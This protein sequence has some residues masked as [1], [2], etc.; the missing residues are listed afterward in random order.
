VTDGG[1]TTYEITS[2]ATKDG[3]ST[4]I[5]SYVAI[6]PPT[7]GVS[8]FD[9]ALCSL[10]G[11]IVLE[12]QTETDGDEVQGGDVYA[13]GN[14]ILSG[15]AEVNGDAIATGTIEKGTKA[16]IAGAEIEG[17]TNPPAPPDINYE[18]YQMEALA[19]DC[20]S[21]PDAVSSW[22]NPAGNYVDPVRVIVDMNISGTGTWVFYDKVC[23]G[24]NLNIS[25][26][27]SVVFMQ[28]VKVQGDINISTSGN[29]TFEDTV[30]VGD[31]LGISSRTTLYLG[32][33]VYVVDQ[34]NIS[35]QADLIGA[36]TIVAGGTIVLSGQSQLPTESIP[37]IIS[38][39]P[40]TAV[41]ISGQ[42]WTCAMIYAPNGNIALSGKSMLYG[43]AVGK[44]IAG[45]GQSTIVYPAGMD[46]RDDLPRGTGTGGRMTVLVYTVQ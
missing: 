21:I 29:I 14:V 40:D 6:I 43:A 24:R 13:V 25:S 44:D 27:A 15:K 17:D 39:A 26:S 33:T 3:G 12:G 38:L 30:Y 10:D 20:E 45:S 36:E 5:V 34:I 1:D 23:I 42:S 41:T 31:D 2:T 7:V 22:S 37:L 11:D 46:S 32:G 19:V 9:Y 18:A 8:P 16:Y 35:G 4:D 28:P